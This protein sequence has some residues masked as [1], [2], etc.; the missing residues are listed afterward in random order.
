MKRY[1]YIIIGIIAVAVLAVILIV[2]IKKGGSTSSLFGFSGSLPQAGTQTTGGNA[3][4]GNNASPNNT[5]GSG[6]GTVALSNGA[7]AQTFGIVSDSPI[8]DYFVDVSNTV[9]A[10][11]PNGE[12]I[13][14]ANGTT[15]VISSTTIPNIIS[16]SF[17][18]DGAKILVSSGDPADPQTDIFSVRSASWASGPKGMI[19]PQWSPMHNYDIAYLVQQPS[20]LTTLAVRNAADLAQAPVTKTSIM[21][22]SLALQWPALDT[23]ILSEKP[24][25]NNNGSIWA[26]NAAT[27]KF[28][29]IAYELAGAES[30]WGT[31][32]GS[33]MGV[34]FNDE[35]LTSQSFE[36]INSAGAPVHTLNFITLPPKCTFAMTTTTVASGNNA[37]PTSTATTTSGSS[38]TATI[39]TSSPYLYCGIPSDQA[40]F[41]KASLPDAY[42]MMALF[43]SDE[44]M[45]INLNNGNYSILR[46]D[47]TPH[48]DATDLKVVNNI[49]FFVNRYD[50]KLYALILPQ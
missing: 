15:T 14:I 27:G 45:R 31:M 8:L 12:V 9:T 6:S 50:E 43:T 49:L 39:A 11:E 13:A 30:R 33:L 37:V 2:S 35:G 18:Y 46:S 29:S 44:L 42:N 19:S 20:G 22:T 40:S 24:T 7:P 38:A 47:S 28:S 26:F 10:V 5:S 32:N 48:V 4:Y 17:S 3:Q 36:L 16:A 34:L 21:A 25:N 23:F 41:T 1:L